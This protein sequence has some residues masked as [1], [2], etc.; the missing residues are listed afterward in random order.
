LIPD[1]QVC[2]ADLMSPILHTA[3]RTPKLYL[4]I[5]LLF[6]VCSNLSAQQ[7]VADL[8]LQTFDTRN[9]LSQNLVYDI[10][11][12]KKGFI[13]FG[14]DEGLNR[15]DG[16]EFRIF[17]HERNN[18]N[19]LIDN[20]VHSVA[21]DNDGVLWIGTSNGISRYYPETEFM[22]QLPVDT[23]DPS[24]PH[25]NSVNDIRIDS[26]GNI[27]IAYLG[28]GVDLYDRKKKQ[29]IQYAT[30]EHDNTRIINDYVIAMQFMPNGDNLLGTRSGIQFIGKNGLPLTRK[31][32]DLKYPWKSKIDNSIKALYLCEDKKT[33]LIGSELNGFYKV[34]LVT[35][36]VKNY[37]TINNQ[38][39][40]NNNIPSVFEDSRGNIWIGG[41]AIYLFDKALDKLIPFDEFGIQGNV[42]N[43]NPVLSIFEDKDNNVWLGT[44]RFGVLKYNPNNTR[45]LHFHTKQGEGSITNDQILSFHED[46]EG[47]LW[48]GT[49]GGGLFSMRPGIR[50]FKPA[51]VD[52]QFSSQVIK[53]MYEDP[54]GNFWIG[55]WDGGMMKYRP[56]TK[57]LEVFHP[58]RGNFESRHVWD[59]KPDS[60]GNLWI[61]T[62]REGLIYF[63]PKTNTYKYFRSDP[64]DPTSLPNND[65]MCVFVDSRNILW[66]ATSDGLCI[67]TPGSNKFVS[68]DKQVLNFTVLSIT[69][70]ENQKMWLGTNGGGIVIADHNFRIEKRITE[71][72][73]LPSSTICAMEADQHQNIWVSTYNGLVKI[74]RDDHSISEVPQIAGLQGK[75][76]IPR[77]SFGLSNGMLAFGGVNGFNLFYPDSL[78][79]NPSP[80]KVVFTSLKINNDEITPN[81][82]YHDRKIINKSIAE[83]DEIT[84][85]HE[86]YSF[87]LTFASLSFNWQE[88]LHFAYM[89]EDLDQEWQHVTA[90]K[91]FIHYTSLDP[92][93]YTLK[94]K[95]SFDGKRWPDEARTLI[96]HITPPWWATWWFRAAVVLAL[97]F[98][99]FAI[100]RTRIR[101][102]KRQ[103]VKLEGLVRQRTVE[104]KKSNDEIQSLLKEVAEQKEQIEHQMHELRQVNEEIGAQRDT[105]EIRGYE[106]ERTQHKLKEINANLEELVDKR[107]QRL[108]DALREL[109]TFLYRASHDLRGPISSMLGL[110]GAARLEKDPIRYNKMYTDFLQRTVLALDRTLQ[111]LLQKHTI[112]KKKIYP[113]RINRGTFLILLEEI[114]DEIPFYRPDDFNLSLEDDLHLETDRM[115]LGIVL[116]NLLENAFFYSEP[117]PDKKVQLAVRQ[118]DN[119]VIISVED[120][121]PGIKHELRDKIFT[122][123]YRGNERSNGNGLGLYLVRNVLDK[124]HGSISLDTEEGKYSR[125]IVTLPKHN[126]AA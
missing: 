74:N 42:K 22:E 125:F 55:T 65:I 120:H 21:V 126:Q 37:N 32:A 34:D 6:S 10:V 119:M 89:L 48:V 100:Y 24:K 4:F 124:I 28:S 80:K 66:V 53:C 50:G 7:Q 2:F 76:F 26:S 29:F 45:I 23:N 98:L 60:I 31:Q 99:L 85:S 106:L 11:Q 94:V 27:W 101:F 16:H 33:L 69:E 41:E 103:Q 114:L 67:L 117:S 96:I 107:T 3:K 92:G 64:D 43:R 78:H 68:W 97:L 17:R 102:L 112:E 5:A 123:F 111:K 57:K 113:E 35:H 15:F 91:R 20:S 58:E 44:F 9:G 62:L 79:F 90:E 39:L 115:L 59:I 81:T 52:Q 36:E 118:S 75:E 12:D 30:H 108:S 51:P 121:G 13:W 61:G 46:K 56:K 88:S 1:Y 47:N 63:S 95:A 54:S 122:M 105:L 40:F 110:I 84:L 109:E 93:K 116:G 8:E 83:T 82:T 19:S 71:K 70:D 86:D 38:L 87:T 73:G 77:S 14:T 49:D 104:L 72:E 18:P 25:G